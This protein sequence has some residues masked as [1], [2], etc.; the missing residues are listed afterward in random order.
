MIFIFRKDEI[1]VQSESR[2]QATI[3]ALPPSTIKSQLGLDPRC[4]QYVWPGQEHT[5]CTKLNVGHD[6]P[7]GY[8]FLKLRSV[9][10]AFGAQAGL[11][12]RAAQVAEWA[13]SHRFCGVCATP[14]HQSNKELC[15][16]CSTCGF[17][18]YPRISPA[19][20]ILIKKGKSILLAKHTHYATQRYSAL[21]GFVEAGES[22]EE[23]IHREVQEEVGL[24]VDKIRYFGSQSWPFPHSLM[25]AYT[26]EY[27]AGEL[28]RQKD[29]IEDV[30]WFGPGDALPDIPAIDSIA[31]RLIR[32]NLP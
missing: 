6:I 16:H 21:A 18:A 9:I 8:E 13:R 31:G 4:W 24:Q 28:S 26:A 17:S 7:V 10:S 32:A 12:G 27:K 25:V 30:R 3:P 22:L 1:L 23:T 29:E 20:M 15:F 5:L 14:M 11:L 19:M 2:Q